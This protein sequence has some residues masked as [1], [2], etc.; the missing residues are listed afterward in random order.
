M[1]VEQVILLPADVKMSDQFHEFILQNSMELVEDL[2]LP[3]RLLQLCS[4][5]LAL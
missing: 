2:G 4:G 3:Y 5:D 1:K